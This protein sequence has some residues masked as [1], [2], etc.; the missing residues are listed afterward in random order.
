ML[1]E[2]P[3]ELLLVFGLLVAILTFAAPLEWLLI[4][5]LMLVTY[6]G[7]WLVSKV[8]VDFTD[9][10]VAG[11]I[12]GIV[13]RPAERRS[14]LR[15][16]VPHSPQSLMLAIVVPIA[17][18]VLMVIGTAFSLGQGEA[19]D[20]GKLL[21][22]PVGVELLIEAS[23]W[24]IPYLGIWL[25]TAALVSIAYV[26]A[27]VNAEYFAG[28]TSII[29]QVYRYCWRSLLFYPLAVLLIR[30]QKQID[31]LLLAIVLSGTACALMAF[32]QGFAGAEAR[33]PFVTKNVLGG[34]LCMPFLL[35]IG[36][37]LGAPTQWRRRLYGLCALLIARGL[38]FA[39]SRGAFVA[40]FV[41]ACVLVYWLVKIPAVRRR[42]LRTAAIGLFL[43]VSALALRP[44]LLDRP[45]VQHMFSTSKGTQDENMRWRIEQRWPHFWH[46]ILQNPILGIGTDIDSSLGD[47]A[48]TP[49]NGYLGLAVVSGIPATILFVVLAGLGVANGRRAF[50]HA[51]SGWQKIAGATI[52]AAIFAL[53]VHNMIDQTFKLPY[54]QK[55]L[56]MAVAFATGLALRPAEFVA[57]IARQ[58]QPQ[59]RTSV[60]LAAAETHS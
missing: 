8:H 36:A 13:L 15:W 26:H 18:M 7:E 53:L 9:I 29:Y 1:P 21:L 3:Q 40:V 28:P 35:S 41:A 56:W 12:I 23:R 16:R 47:S 39:G 52:A 19:I 58:R 51:A 42:T 22:V 24:R 45:N 10:V 59:R 54:T 11:L 6:P 32:Q 43:M 55:G 31:T 5:D 17:A 44:G 27:D 20:I 49:H 33:G 38:L 57:A 30:N 48:V 25:A 4:L 34:A 60:A 14:A 2:L 37:A 50:R 46:K